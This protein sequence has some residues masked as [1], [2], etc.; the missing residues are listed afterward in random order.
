VG[1][2]FDELKRRSVFR[3]GAAY[4]VV[5]W[6]IIEVVDTLAPRMAM[7]EWVPGFVIILV[8]VGFP[9]AIILS[10]AFELT[11][12]GVKKTVEVDADESVTASTGQKLNYLII[13]ALAL[14]LGYFIWERQ[15]LSPEA[16]QK[17]ADT[18]AAPE[19]RMLTSIAVLPFVDMSPE[20]DQEY[21]GDGI[22]EELLNVLVRVE[23]LRVP[24][25]TSSFAFKGENINI[26]QV[27]E[28]LGVGH[29][30]EGSVRKAGNRVRI[31]AQLI[32]VSTDTHLW[33]ETYDRDLTD[34]FAVQD[35]IAGAISEAMQVTLGAGISPSAA[36]GTNNANAY[37]LYLLGRHHWNQRNPDG[38]SR[39]IEIFGQAIALDPTF[40]RAHS[41]L[42]LVYT[43][44]PD[45]AKFNHEVAQERAREAAE[46]ALEIE[47]TS[48]EAMAVLGFYYSNTLDEVRAERTFQQAIALEPNYSTGHHW[49]GMMLLKLAR[50]DEAQLEL[51][52][53][54]R[55]EPASLAIHQASSLPW[56]YRRQFE[57]ALEI[58]EQ[59]LSRLPR[60]R[61]ALSWSFHINVLKGAPEN[62][63]ERL[64][65]FLE[66]IGEDPALGNTIIA[67]LMDASK[68]P[69]GRAAVID[70][71]SRHRS[72][73]ETELMTALLMFTGANE[74]AMD[75]LEK[76]TPFSDVHSAAYD[77]LRDDPRF[78]ALLERWNMPNN[79]P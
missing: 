5:G 52:I 56:F 57:K 3:V 46:R 10:W 28:T 32:D 62:G 8:L 54:R 13:G 4:L 7:P 21:L 35:D 33:S 16:S 24:S 39:A 41:G 45:Y 6:L 20:G 79:R 65:A 74:A 23:G 51:D 67:G 9:L 72:A 60:Y 11:P 40:A 75:V 58:N 17:S 71:A 50:F 15:S 78:K 19:A 38:L 25:R 66:V 69:E 31:T 14:A 49:Y 47:P 55:L 30:L 29:I 43:V 44:I 77:P 73:G 1:N 27:A 48:A 12:D 2:L 36:V 22:A 76:T 18:Q 64:N 53:A 63:R 61:N 26:R 42:G 59:L 70:I 68:L 34:I 37:D